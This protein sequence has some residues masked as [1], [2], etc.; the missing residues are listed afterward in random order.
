MLWTC[1]PTRAPP[2][3]ATQFCRKSRSNVKLV[4]R[5]ALSSI[6]LDSRQRSSRGIHVLPVNSLRITLESGAW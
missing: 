6:E 1:V 3:S 5:S 4:S 2:D